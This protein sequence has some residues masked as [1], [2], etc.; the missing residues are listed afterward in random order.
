MSRRLNATEKL[1]RDIC[2]AGFNDPKFVG[3][4]KARY[5]ENIS[6]AAKMDY[7]REA[8]Y[9]A[10]LVRKLGRETIDAILSGPAVSTKL[11]KSAS[12]PAPTGGEAIRGSA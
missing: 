12:H 1:A 6:D 9:V 7:I 3:K 5:W 11:S 2:W 4:S 10:R 8:G